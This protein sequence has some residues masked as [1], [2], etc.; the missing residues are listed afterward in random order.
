MTWESVTL[1][2]RSYTNVF[3][4]DIGTAARYR[5]ETLELYVRL[6]KG[7]VGYNLILMDDDPRSHYFWKVGSPGGLSSQISRPQPHV[8]CLGFFKEG[9]CNS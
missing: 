6:F 9:N 3:E 4:R 8:P 5:N 1:D 7:G 2:C